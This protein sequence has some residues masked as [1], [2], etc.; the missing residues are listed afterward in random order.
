VPVARRPLGDVGS[1][2]VTDGID[3]SRWWTLDE[4][5]A[6]EEKIWPGGLADLVRSLRSSAF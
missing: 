6:T 3:G 2:H 5:D 1:M 4:L